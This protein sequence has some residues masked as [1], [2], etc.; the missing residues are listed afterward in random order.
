MFDCS[1]KGPLAQINLAPGDYVTAVRGPGRGLEGVVKSVNPATGQ[2]VMKLRGEYAAR[3]KGGELDMP[4]SEV[5]KTFQVRMRVMCFSCAAVHACAKRPGLPREGHSGLP[6]CLALLG[7]GAHVAVRATL[8]AAPVLF[9]HTF[10]L[11]HMEKTYGTS[12]MRACHV[13]LMRCCG[14]V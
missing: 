2:F 12:G 13:L 5:K 9:A 11:C 10:G 6:A 1:F 4:I 14:C 7:R 3:V 8:V